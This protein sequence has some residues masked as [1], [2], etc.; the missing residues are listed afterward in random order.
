MIKDLN[1]QLCVAI[2]IFLC[3]EPENFLITALIEIGTL[4]LVALLGKKV[5][6]RK[7]H[8]LIDSLFEDKVACTILK[9]PDWDNIVRA[10]VIVLFLSASDAV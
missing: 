7:Y 10:Q 3:R 6:I 2:S 1:W 5:Y 8:G 4:V 9:L